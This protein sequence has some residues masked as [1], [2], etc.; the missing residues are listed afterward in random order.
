LANCCV[1]WVRRGLRVDVP[2][3]TLHIS[4]LKD[5]FRLRYVQRGQSQWEVS[6]IM[7][8]RERLAFLSISWSISCCLVED[9]D[10]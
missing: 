4:H 6:S 7:V 8:M 9:L 2:L 5:S 10:E 1:T 3:R